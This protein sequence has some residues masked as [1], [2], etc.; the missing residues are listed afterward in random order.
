[1]SIEY[2]ECSY[3][4]ACRCWMAP[5]HLQ[6]EEHANVMQRMLAAGE[7]L[8]QR[9]LEARRHSFYAAHPLELE[10]VIDPKVYV[11]VGRRRFCLGCMVWAER[12][13]DDHHEHR[14]FLERLHGWD[15]ETQD[16]FL[17]RRAQRSLEVMT[18]PPSRGGMPIVLRSRSEAR[19]HVSPTR[20]RLTL[21]SRT[22]QR[23][24]PEAHSTEQDSRSQQPLSP[25]LPEHVVLY[26][27]HPYCLVCQKWD[28]KPHRNSKRHVARVYDFMAND[29]DVRVD[30]VKQWNAQLVKQRQQL[31][32][33]ME[34]TRIYV[35]LKDWRYCLACQQW[36]DSIHGKSDRHLKRVA[37]FKEMT[38]QE[39]AYFLADQR[40]KAEETL[41]G[42]KKTQLEQDADEM[43]PILE[44]AL[45]DLPVDEPPARPAPQMSASSSSA[46]PH[47]SLDGNA[48]V[49]CACADDNDDSLKDSGSEDELGNALRSSLGAGTAAPEADDPLGDV[50]RHVSATRA[51]D[52]QTSRV[53]TTLFVCPHVL[54][55]Q[56]GSVVAG[57]HTT[58]PSKICFVEAGKLI[59]N[60]FRVMDWS[61]SSELDW[62]ATSSPMAGC[63]SAF[64][65]RPT[66]AVIYPAQNILCQDCQNEDHGYLENE[67][68]CELARALQDSTRQDLERMEMH[69]EDVD[70]KWAMIYRPRDSF[71]VQFQNGMTVAEL[72]HQLSRRKR[73]RFSSHCL[74][75]Q[76]LPGE[77]LSDA[78]ELAWIP[79][80]ASRGGTLRITV[81]YDGHEFQAA[82][83]RQDTVKDLLQQ[84]GRPE[85][86]L[87]WTHYWL[88]GDVDL[89]DFVRETLHLEERSPDLQCFRPY[90]LCLASGFITLAELTRWRALPGDEPLE[91]ASD[92]ETTIEARAEYLSLLWRAHFLAARKC[93]HRG[94]GPKVEVCMG[95]NAHLPRSQVHD[96]CGR[97]QGAH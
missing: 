57:I 61:D 75:R 19:A 30:L 95:V 72:H 71:A 59:P 45:E 78:A 50:V 74:M 77:V 25:R 47:H 29:P 21:R 70:V 76:A 42:G 68:D 85:A 64:K 86:I 18:D 37:H 96:G 23:A 20:T 26:R 15:P 52:L 67:N 43:T 49:A 97:R 1:M 28:D 48:A 79:Q 6:T 9:A 73:V 34:E 36:E 90:G 4:L 16:V 56:I 2:V 91:W 22:P 62:Q 14:E 80:K 8:A 94:G 83:A 69:K 7:E 17:A 46:P 53:R 3:C 10:E 54:V 89:I 63:P 38:S 44:D 39:K 33:C 93:H 92:E 51:I 87:R 5:G 31:E 40:A 12:L 82:I 84:L 65:L 66:C 55:E 58:S 13:H 35:Y 81:N 24:K 60:T 41:R 27:K 11:Q 88:H 32:E